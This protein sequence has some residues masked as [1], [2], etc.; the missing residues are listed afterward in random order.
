MTINRVPNKP[1][2]GFD[3]TFYDEI[4]INS[5]RAL[6]E[7]AQQLK[8]ERLMDSNLYTEIL[9]EQYCKWKS[10]QNQLDLP[11]R[12]KEECERIPFLQQC[13]IYDC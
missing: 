8:D 13:K 5:A 11:A 12:F 3:D 2:L 6:E 7:R 4:A 1:Y 9:D 10:T